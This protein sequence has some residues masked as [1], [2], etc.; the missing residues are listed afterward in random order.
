MRGFTSS[1]SSSRR[2]TKGVEEDGAAGARCTRSG[3]RSKRS[4]CPGPFYP[5]PQPPLGRYRQAARPVTS[6]GWSSPSSHGFVIA[7]TRA[8]SVPATEELRRLGAVAHPKQLVGTTQML[9][10]GGL[11]EEQAP[12]YRRPRA[13]PP[14][15][16]RS[17]SGAPRGPRGPPDSSSVNMYRNSSRGATSSPLGATAKARRS[18]PGVISAWTKPEPPARSASRASGRSS[19]GPKT[20][21]V[22]HPG[23]APGSAS[24]ARR[25]LPD[26]WRRV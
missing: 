12:A 18:W 16:P 19:Y 13:P 23:S 4:A 24:H 25:G 2:A 11:R 14:P 20:R 21:T 3:S 17:P 7:A 1:H 8:S 9:L 5:I 6:P 15:T 10:Y 22:A 26:R